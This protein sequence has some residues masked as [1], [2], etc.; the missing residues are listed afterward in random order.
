MGGIRSC[1]RTHEGRRSLN[2]GAKH[3][4]GKEPR[5]L[6]L[7]GMINRHQNRTMSVFCSYRTALLKICEITN[8]GCKDVYNFPWHTVGCGDA[9]RTMIC[10]DWWFWREDCKAKWKD[11]I[12]SRYYIKLYHE[13]TSKISST[14][15]ETSEVPKDLSIINL[16]NIILP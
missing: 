5:L 7:S 15:Q 11:T 6:I 4:R 10:D 8:G 16:R 2:G 3:F 12:E 13:S 1:Q 9:Q 14:S